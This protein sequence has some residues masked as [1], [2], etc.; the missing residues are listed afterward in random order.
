MV[1]EIAHHQIVRLAFGWI[2]L[3]QVVTNGPS[4]LSLRMVASGSSFL[5]VHLLFKCRLISF[6]SVPLESNATSRTPRSGVFRSPKYGYSMSWCIRT[7]AKGIFE[8]KAKCRTSSVSPAGIQDGMGINRSFGDIQ[9]HPK[10]VKKR[11]LSHLLKSNDAGINF[12]KIDRKARF[13]FPVLGSL[14]STFLPPCDP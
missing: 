9:I 8:N 12:F 4:L 5:S 3:S 2:G 13:S 6:H 7:A 14:S 1:I 11:T 10:F